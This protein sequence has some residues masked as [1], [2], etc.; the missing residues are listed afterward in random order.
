MGALLAGVGTAVAYKDEIRRR[1]T[2]NYT[3]QSAKTGAGAKEDMP[4]GTPGETPDLHSLVRQVSKEYLPATP[5]EAVEE[6]GKLTDRFDYLVSKEG[7]KLN[8][9]E[10]KQQFDQLGEALYQFLDRFS[11]QT[12]EKIKE[13]HGMAGEALY[14]Q[15]QK[16]LQEVCQGE[17]V[18]LYR[19]IDALFGQKFNA[20]TRAGLDQEAYDRHIRGMNQDTLLQDISQKR[21]I[22]IS[23]KP[24]EAAQPGSAQ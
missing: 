5:A 14:Q 19:Q 21:N 23:V 11:G 18:R 7:Q 24:P 6:I 13:L 3:W 16:M 17:Y 1:F 15:K 20:A 22:I 8:E 2:G 9:G 4:A 10:Y 12:Q